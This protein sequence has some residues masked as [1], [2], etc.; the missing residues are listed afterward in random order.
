MKKYILLFTLIFA[1]YFAH[2]KTIEICPTCVQ[3]S[4]QGAINSAQEGDLLL[5]KKGTYKEGNI[6]V[7]KSLHLKGENFPIIDGEN[8]NEVITVTANDV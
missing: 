8:K 7:S 6:I 4:I 1:T 2:S 5:I 3:T